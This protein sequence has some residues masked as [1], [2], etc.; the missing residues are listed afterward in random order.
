MHQDI[1]VWLLRMILEGPGGRQVN[2]QGRS[3]DV[4]S[5][6]DAE[7]FWYDCKRTQMTPL[8]PSLLSRCLTFRYLR[9]ARPFS[10]ADWSSLSAWK[11]CKEFTATLFFFSA[12]TLVWG[13]LCPF[14]LMTHLEPPAAAGFSSSNCLGSVLILGVKAVFMLMVGFLTHFMLILPRPK[15]SQC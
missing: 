7:E 11:I 2:W 12:A 10:S 3:H 1:Y 15:A 8:P 4:L 14:L 13:G 5:T 9:D 6:V